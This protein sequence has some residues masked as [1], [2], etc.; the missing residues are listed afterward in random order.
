MSARIACGRSSL[1]EHGELEGVQRGLVPVQHHQLGRAERGDL[2][3]QLGTDRTACAGHEHPL[4]LQVS[5]DLVH[6]GVDLAAAQQVG[7]VDVT[8]V[9]DAYSA[10]Q[11]VGEARQHLHGQPGLVGALRDVADQLG[12]G[13]GQCDHED[14]CTGGGD[15]AAHPFAAA[16]HAD[17]PDAG[18]SLRR[19]VVQQPDREIGALRVAEHRPDEL[20]AG[21]AGAEDERRLPGARPNG[22]LPLRADDH[23]DGHHE[24]EGEDSG[25]Q[26]NTQR[27]QPGRPSGGVDRQ[28][29]ERRQCDRRAQGLQF[30]G[31]SDAVPPLVQS[32]DRRGRREDERGDD[33]SD[34]QSGAVRVVQGTLVPGRRGED[35]ARMQGEDIR[36]QEDAAREPPPGQELLVR[37]ADLQ[38]GT[39]A[40]SATA[41]GIG[42]P[43]AL[44][45]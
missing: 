32:Q 24:D 19:I 42:E 12:V 43:S 17:P 41:H 37:H 25:D 21:V 33:D 14:F 18:V 7:D 16:E 6:V 45:A 15:G 22:T 39:K 44:G 13:G 29:G 31:G 38:A 40:S 23:P 8:D 20:T 34:Q 27:Q 28:H 35:E 10:V 5:R 26:G 36:H 3:A 4:V 9:A 11:E 1:S 2:P 30:I